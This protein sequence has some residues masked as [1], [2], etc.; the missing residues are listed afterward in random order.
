MT[1]AT[2]DTSQN[3]QNA[4]AML[5]LLSIGAPD[6]AEGGTWLADNFSALAD[7]YNNNAENAER[8]ITIDGRV[9]TLQYVK[10]DT[11]P[12]MLLTISTMV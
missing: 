11:T 1:A 6:W 3:A 2:A 5:L 8:H 10:L 12:I 4:A 9:I 7:E